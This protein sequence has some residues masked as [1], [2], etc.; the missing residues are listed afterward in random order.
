MLSAFPGHAIICYVGRT[1]LVR[2]GNC[3][4][5]SFHRGSYL[6]SLATSEGSQKLS[7]GSF[8]TW[9]HNHSIFRVAYTCIYKDMI[10]LATSCS[11]TCPPSS[12]QW[13][14]SNSQSKSSQEKLRFSL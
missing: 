12:C 13:R 2:T 10:N 1:A 3:Q 8:T 11:F 6:G 7:D 14:L 9:Q 5:I 4:L